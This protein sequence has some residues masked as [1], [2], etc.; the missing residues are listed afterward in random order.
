MEEEKEKG[1]EKESKKMKPSIGMK[2]S[3]RK[4]D[5]HNVWVG[6]FSSA[7]QTCKFI[8][9]PCNLSPYLQGDPTSP[10]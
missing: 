9:N 8:L 4:K 1:E 2:N 5:S 10:S 7:T 6:E 3:A